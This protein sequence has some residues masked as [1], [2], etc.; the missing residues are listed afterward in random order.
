MVCNLG[1]PRRDGAQIDADQLAR[2]FDVSKTVGQRGAS[3]RGATHGLEAPFQLELLGIGL[4]EL[5]FAGVGQDE[6]IFLKRAMVREPT[7]GCSQT[8]FPVAS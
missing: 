1:I 2:A 8:S 7:C 3:A 6:Q 4:D 5:Q